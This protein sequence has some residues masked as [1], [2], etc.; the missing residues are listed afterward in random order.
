MQPTFR[1]QLFIGGEYVFSASGK[2][3]SVLNPANNEVLTELAEA[4]V[5]DVNRAVAAARKAFD[6]GPWPKMKAAER[7]KLLRRFAELV[8]KH[9]PELEQIESLDVGKP[10]KESGG[11][12]I[13]R[14]ANNFSFLLM[15]FRSGRKTLTGA[16]AIRLA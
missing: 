15:R 3:F 4:G 2:T 11:H 8:V 5:E 12:D 7:A 6:E 16:K 1:S 14:A 9:A 10:V 13:P